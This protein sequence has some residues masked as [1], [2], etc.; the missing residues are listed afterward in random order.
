MLHPITRS[1]GDDAWN[2]D[3]TSGPFALCLLQLVLGINS[4]VLEDDF[5]VNWNEEKVRSGDK[6]IRH[7]SEARIS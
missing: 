4:E 7:E 1:A 6:N 2:A 5:A 3:A